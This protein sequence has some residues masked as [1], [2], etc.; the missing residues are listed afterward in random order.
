MRN[1]MQKI[2]IVTGSYGFIGFHLSLLLLSN[3]WSV[4]GLD[5]MSNYYDVDL[6]KTR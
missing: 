6:K 5:S 3:A 1:N 4:I 2:A